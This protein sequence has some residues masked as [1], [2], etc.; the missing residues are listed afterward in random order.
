VN[1]YAGLR[2][3][4]VHDYP[5]ITLILTQTIHMGKD[6]FIHTLINYLYNFK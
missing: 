5:S 4:E 6:N 2:T 3:T 1:L